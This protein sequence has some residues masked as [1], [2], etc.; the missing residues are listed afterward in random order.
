MCICQRRYPLFFLLGFWIFLSLPEAAAFQDSQVEIIAHT[1]E[2]VGN[3][4]TASGSVEIHYRDIKVFADWIELNTETKDIV[5][6]GGVHIHL[7]NEVISMEEVMFNLDSSRGEMKEV[8]GLVQPSITYEAGSVERESA[9]LFHLRDAWI[10]SCTQTVPRWK[11][12][13]GRADFK[14][15]DYVAMWNSV[16]YIKKIPVFYLPYMRYPLETQRSTGFLIPKLGYNGRKG[17]QLSQSF[18]WDIR[19]NM[20]ATFNVDY[21]SHKGL[22]GGLQHRYILPGDMAGELNLFYFRFREEEAQLYDTSTAYILRFQHQQPLP[23]DFR[24]VAD[25]DYQ[26]SFDFLR[27]FDN[28]FYRAVAANRSSQ[29]YVSRSWSYFNFN[30]RASRFETYFTERDRSVIRK[31][32]P[33]ISFTSSK[34]KVFTP[35]YLSFSSS[36]QRWEYGWDTAYE[37]GTQ[38]SAQNLS[39]SPRLNFPF[40][41]LPWLTINSNLSSQLTYYFQSYALDRNEVVPEPLFTQN[42]VYESEFT[43]PVFYRVF[44]DSDGLPRWKHIIEPNLTYRYESPVS[45][46]DRIIT[47]RFFY[48]NH[49]LSY[50][51]T[52]R[53]LVKEQNSAREIFTLGISQNYYFDPESGPLQRYQVD[54]EVPAF[55]DVSGYLRFYP[56][57]QYSVDVSAAFNPYFKTFARMRMGASLGRP[58]DN[59]FFRANW[60]KSINPYRPGTLASRHQVG[61]SGGLKIPA[62]S[63][64][65]RGNIDINIQTR[66]ILYS[67]ASLVYHYQCLDF[68]ADLRVFYFRDKPEIQFGFTLALGNIGK[69][70]DF[71]GGAEF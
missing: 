44:F 40:N 31:S 20:D 36:F 66:E 34:I 14:K 57:R 49:Y 7:P 35:L 21:Y 64:E 2:R 11:F 6:A 9:S 15:E 1:K 39:F 5:A 29:V 67:A 42:L 53:I 25:V 24:L 19:R 10:T 46:P 50:G 63:L 45:S 22:G 70:T 51:L 3:R 58:E 4:I 13:F 30:M 28:N 8:H 17:F 41:A 37:A 12:Q 23:Y 32:L 55:S 61:F 59:W 47:T 62:L 48:L 16:F 65:T 54:G 56:S 52:N 68:A 18:Y 60:Y 71:L 33:E 26:S 43:G 38:R 69:T 27:E